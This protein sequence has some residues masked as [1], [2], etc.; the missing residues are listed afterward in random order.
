MGRL[1]DLGTVEKGKV[2]DLVLLDAN[3][4]ED[5]GNTRTIRAVVLAGQYF[6]RADLDQGRPGGEIG[7]DDAIPRVLQHINAIADG[8]A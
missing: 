1:A 7:R 3:P 2:A 5:I 4:L 8:D 6:S